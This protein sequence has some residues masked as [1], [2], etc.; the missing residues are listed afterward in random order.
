MF[1]CSWIEMEVYIIPKRRIIWGNLRLAM[2]CGGG[3]KLVLLWYSRREKMRA[4]LGDEFWMRFAILWILNHPAFQLYVCLSTL[5][6]YQ[7][8]LV[9]SP[10][11]EIPVDRPVFNAWLN[12]RLH[13]GLWLWWSLLQRGG[14]RPPSERLGPA[15]PSTCAEAEDRA[16]GNERTQQQFGVLL[17]WSRC[18]AFGMIQ[19]RWWDILD[20][21]YIYNYM[22]NYDDIIK[23]HIRVILG[24]NPS[25]CPRRRPMRVQTSKNT[26]FCGTKCTCPWSCFHL[27]TQSLATCATTTTTTITTTTIIILKIPLNISLTGVGFNDSLETLLKHLEDS[28][29]HANQYPSSMYLETVEMLWGRS[30]GG[31]CA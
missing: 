6:P 18:L 3:R 12:A 7:T 16:G 13:L 29:K 17:F 30:R 26:V 15:A 2:R 10:L 9:S 20:M 8:L 27:A 14:L 19:I 21:L 5:K 1:F 23:K 31:C 24:A 11:P 22:M 4:T 28:L 25:V